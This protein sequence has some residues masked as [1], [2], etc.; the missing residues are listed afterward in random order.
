MYHVAGS[1]L[2]DQEGGD[3]RCCCCLIHFPEKLS[4]KAWLGISITVTKSNNACMGIWKTD[5]AEF[6]LCMLLNA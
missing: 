5:I 4:V 2:I 3:I 1:C 6:K